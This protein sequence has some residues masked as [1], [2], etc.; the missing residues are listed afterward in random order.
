MSIL[1]DK[2]ENKKQ[3]GIL[4]VPVF[5]VN[6]VLMRRSVVANSEE[7]Q[8]EIEDRTISKEDPKKDHLSEHEYWQDESTKL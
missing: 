7:E 2:A 3:V 8:N 1:V 4:F 6:S 5:L